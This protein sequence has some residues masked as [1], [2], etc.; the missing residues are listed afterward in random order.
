M[1]A[2]P[3]NE[4]YLFGGFLSINCGIFAISPA[5]YNCDSPLW[6]LLDRTPGIDCCRVGTVPKLFVSWKA[7]TSETQNSHVY[8]GGYWEF[9]LF[10]MFFLKSSVDVTAAPPPN[11]T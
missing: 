6:Q 7:K 8:E 11:Q 10:L 9:R 1:E 5:I 4:G 3:K 2:F